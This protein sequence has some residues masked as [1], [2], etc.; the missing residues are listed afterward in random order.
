MDQ[1][2]FVPAQRDGMHPGQCAEIQRNGEHVGYIG[3]IHPSVQAELDLSRPVVMAE[4]RLS[5]IVES[6]LPK[7]KEISKFPEI[8]RDLAIVVDKT[9]PSSSILGGIYEVGGILLKSVR[10]FDVYEGKGVEE[11]KRSLAVALI[12]QDQS[13]TLLDQDVNASIDGVIGHLKDRYQATL[14]A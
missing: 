8:R 12:Y 7:F 9:I 3:M 11:G 14:R 5:Q 2:S 1:F 13:R 6:K 4:L 10:L